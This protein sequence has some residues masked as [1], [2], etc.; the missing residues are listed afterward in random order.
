[1]KAPLD[2]ACAYRLWAPTYDAENVVT[3]LEDRIVRS[4]TP[5]L[6]D[7]SLLDVACGTGRRLPH[8]GADLQPQRVVGVDLVYEM[9]TRARSQ[10]HPAV[11]VGDMCALPCRDRSFDLIWC[12]L[13]IGHV[14]DP[15]A[16][17]RELARVARA[18]ACVVITDFHAAAV[19]AGHTR[20]FRDVDGELHEVV[21]HVHSLDEH[22]AGATSAGL[23][24]TQTVEGVVDP[25]IRDHYERAGR[26][27]LYEQQLGL[28]LVLALVFT[29]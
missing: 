4:I 23:H 7:R 14:A 24:L 20:S 29:A 10:G 12:R 9:V 2:P 16:A 15:A 18:G 17:Y 21:H 13:A 1:M 26:V 5:S 3:T 25:S 19:S 27:D 11:A 28:S 6:G 8:A 22:R